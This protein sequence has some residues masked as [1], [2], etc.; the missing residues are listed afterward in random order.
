MNENE[1]KHK[2]EQA[3]N[4]RDKISSE[5]EILEQELR[6]AAA[7]KPIKAFEID[8][9]KVFI[10]TFRNIQIESNLVGGGYVIINKE[11]FHD[12]ILK[13]RCV[14]LQMLL[15]AEKQDACQETN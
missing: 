14:E 8:V 13:L 4:D 11:V 3:K 7:E 10:N 12:F 1:I 2:L 6:P 9:N 5:V 15:D